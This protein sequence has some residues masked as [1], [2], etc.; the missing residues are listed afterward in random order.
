MGRALW[1]QEAHLSQETRRWLGNRKRY[2]H[3]DFFKVLFKGREAETPSRSWG[4]GPGERGQWFG[5]GREQQVGWWY[6]AKHKT[7]RLFVLLKTKGCE[8]LWHVSPAV[9]LVAGIDL[10][11][12]RRS[13]P[14]RETGEWPS[15]IT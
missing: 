7:Y 11:L 14:G 8:C 4:L 1:A 15:F 5:P 2:T 9:G 3:S 10:D 13:A 12:G 6:N